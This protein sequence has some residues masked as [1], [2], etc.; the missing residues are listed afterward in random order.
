MLFYSTTQEVRFVPPL[1]K[2]AAQRWHKA[3]RFDRQTHT[4]TL[5][6]DN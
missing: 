3:G 6:A 5:G 4:P 1:K 2:E